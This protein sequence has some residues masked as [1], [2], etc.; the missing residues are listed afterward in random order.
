MNGENPYDSIQTGSG[1]RM[2]ATGLENQTT[3]A[4]RHGGGD[5]MR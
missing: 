4:G 2:Q 1:L 3:C 5:R